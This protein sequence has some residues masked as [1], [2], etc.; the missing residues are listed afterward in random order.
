MYIHR[1]TY[2]FIHMYIHTSMCVG[3]YVDIVRCI[4]IV[5]KHV[6]ALMNAI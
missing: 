6:C 1:Y 4:V 2:I 5:M 3:I